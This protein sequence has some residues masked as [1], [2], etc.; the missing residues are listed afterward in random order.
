MRATALGR[1]R[2]LLLALALSLLLPVGT[3]EPADAQVPATYEELIVSAGPVGYW[4]FD[5][6]ACDPWF[7]SFPSEG[8]CRTNARLGTI[9]GRAFQN[10]NLGGSTSLAGGG[11]APVFSSSTDFSSG[12]YMDPFDAGGGIH[13]PTLHVNALSLELWVQTTTDSTSPQ[14]LA[15]MDDPAYSGGGGYVLELTADERPRGTVVLET[16]Q[17][18]FEFIEVV[19][20]G[21]DSINDG[22]PHH[23]VLTKD[24]STIRLYVD[25]VQVDSAPS[26]GLPTAYDVCLC[27]LFD[28]AAFY[29][30]RRLIQSET[31][32]RTFSGVIDEVAIYDRALSASVVADH[33]NV[34]AT[35]PSGEI[36]VSSETLELPAISPTSNLE[37]IRFVDAQGQGVAN[38][39]LAF[40][41]QDVVCFNIGNIWSFQFPDPCTTDSSGNALFY[42]TG[43]GAAGSSESFSISS[44]LPVS[45]EQITAT[46]DVVF[47][48]PIRL[49]GLGDSYS[50]GQSVSAQYGGECKRST[51]AYAAQYR[52]SGYPSRISS[53]GPPQAGNPGFVFPACAGARG[54][55][56]GNPPRW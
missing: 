27:S 41:T 56:A 8:S 28:E 50:S 14:A 55:A 37:T 9:D 11:A 3:I 2:Y 16:S 30:G 24:N 18:P 33:S 32:P 35:E 6:T 49:A 53:Y 51:N 10:V 36:I 38:A 4:R 15:G 45:G 39:E 44:T 21:P 1:N 47:Y 25:G 52:A 43:T 23:L 42:Y 7:P 22:A 19:V 29:V 13:D 5:E 54:R 31:N 46:V 12:M 40:T 17:N 26:N 34:G 48:E 20:T